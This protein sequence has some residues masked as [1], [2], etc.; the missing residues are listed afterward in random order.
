MA[1]V[2]RGGRSR[3]IEQRGRLR[4]DT[5]ED[6][7]RLGMGEDDGPVRGRGLLEAR[8]WFSDPL[9]RSLVGSIRRPVSSGGGSDGTD[10]CWRRLGFGGWPVSPLFSW[11]LSGGRHGM[12]G[13]EKR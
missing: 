12:L 11:G 9:E 6:S 10:G 1:S 3:Y 5:S 8:D 13:C 2:D 4:Q 7:L